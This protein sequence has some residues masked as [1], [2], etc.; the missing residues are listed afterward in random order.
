MLVMLTPALVCGP[1]M[2]PA[3]AAAAT[4]AEH[5]MPNCHGMTMGEQSPQEKA[6]K[7]THG[8]MLFKDCAKID[9]SGAADLAP[10]KKP[11]P[12]NAPFIVWADLPSQPAFA[13]TGFHAIR[14]PPPGWPAF[15]AIVPSILLTTQ[16][17]RV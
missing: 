15:S 9:L 16:R 4:A 17:L 10:L 14:G 11:G 6:Q 13:P 5:A 8:T 12:D 3:K 7:Q 2:A 1:F